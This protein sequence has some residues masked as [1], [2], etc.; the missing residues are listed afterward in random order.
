MRL[1]ANAQNLEY[2]ATTEKG[3]WLV[4]VANINK[5]AKLTLIT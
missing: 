1:M 5:C 3:K 2:R 4:S